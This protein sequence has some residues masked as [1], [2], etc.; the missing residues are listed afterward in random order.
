MFS[1]KFRKIIIVICSIVIC[2][3]STSLPLHANSLSNGKSSEIGNSDNG[4]L[5]ADSQNT[6]QT[7]SINSSEDSSI[8]ES[9]SVSGVSS[10][11]VTNEY[12]TALPESVS[13]ATKGIVQVNSI[14]TNETGKEYIIL[15]CTGFLIGNTEDGEYVI[16]TNSVVAPTKGTRDDAF[17]TIGV[18]EE[19]EDWDKINLSIKVVVEGDVSITAEVITRSPELNIAVVK[20]S[21]PLYNRTPLSILTSDDYESAKPYK[22]TEKVYALGFPYAVRYDRNTVM[23]GQDDVTMSSGSIANNKTY[24]DIYV[25]EHD[26]LITGNNCG[27]PLI[28]SSGYVIGINEQKKDGRYYCSVDCSELVRILDALGI[29]YSKVTTSEYEARNSSE[30]STTEQVETVDSNVFDQIPLGIIIAVVVIVLAIFASLII[31]I[32]ILMSQKND[33]KNDNSKTVKKK[34]KEEMPQPR[35]VLTPDHHANETVMLSGGVSAETSVLD[36][37]SSG[38]MYKSYGTLIRKSNN[39]NCVIDKPCFTIGKDSLHVDFCIK[40]N[41]SISRQHATIESKN[42]LMTI[43]DNN[44]TNGTYLNNQRISTNQPQ[45]LKNG[46]VITLANEEFVYRI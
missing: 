2:V 28:N 40:D 14:Y 24:N 38:S 19:K 44:S 33:A 18:D 12:A 15:G 36:S 34:E 22:A 20:L 7:P 35:Q 37:I 8:V 5:E 25:I 3:S 41:G 30:S 9:E 11:N 17:E 1:H 43:A 27:G 46:D 31:L 45:I 13:D 4:I 29:V 42:G 6:N 26:C 10:V 39:E 16:T 21:Q 32:T 23:Y